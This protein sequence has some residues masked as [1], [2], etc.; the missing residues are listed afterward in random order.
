MSAPTTEIPGYIAG[1]WVIDGTHSDVTFTVRHLGVSKVRGRFDQVETTIVTAEK[2]ADSTVTA[3][4]HTASIDTNNADR[5]AHV[6]GG[7][8]LDVENFPAMTFTS[9]AV[10]EEDGEYFIDGELTLRGVTK[11]VTLAAE[12]GGFGNGMAEGSKVL[13]ISASTEISRTDFGVG[14][15]VPGAVVSDKIKIELDIE[16]GLQA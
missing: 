16:A 9:T 10:R 7:D 11:P 14:S 8:F 1:T 12:L 6:R 13:G 5:D 2:F 3:T 4:I 15:G